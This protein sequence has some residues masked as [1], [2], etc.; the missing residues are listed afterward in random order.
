M[1]GLSNDLNRTRVFC[2]LYEDPTTV[3]PV[4]GVVSRVG[5]FE[6]KE[7]YTVYISCKWISSA[8]ETEQTDTTRFGPEE[9]RLMERAPPPAGLA[10]F[11]VFGGFR[12]LGVWGLKS[13]FVIF[14]D[15]WCTR[16]LGCRI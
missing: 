13:C 5:M 16:D 2:S 15:C 3:T 10:L 6:V 9:G 8:T 1:H 11:R 7:C 4:S 14:R 12:G